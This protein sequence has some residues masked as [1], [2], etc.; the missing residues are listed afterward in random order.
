MQRRLLHSQMAGHAAV[1]TVK[2]LNPH[3]SNADIDRFHTLRQTG[4]QP[5]VPCLILFPLTQVVLEGR[6]RQDD[7]EQYGNHSERRAKG[8]HQ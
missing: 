8:F 3:L 5:V 4:N 1:H 2:L 7:E 6:D